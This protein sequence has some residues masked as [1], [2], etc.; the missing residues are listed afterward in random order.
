M[1]RYVKDL[2]QEVFEMFDD[3]IPQLQH[4]EDVCGD[5][6]IHEHIIEIALRIPLPETKQYYFLFVQ[7]LLPFLIKG[8][9]G[10]LSLQKS[11]TQLF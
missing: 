8:L 3:I 4:M 9:F 11:G 10:P 5:S 2:P 1:N 6:Y 7:K